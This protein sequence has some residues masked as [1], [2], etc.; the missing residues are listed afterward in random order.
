MKAGKSSKVLPGFVYGGIILGILISLWFLFRTKPVEVETA[1]VT[2]GPFI[3]DFLIDGKVRSKNKTTVVA[4][5]NGDVD[6]INLRPGDSIV[7]G[8]KITVLHW[9]YSK[10]IVSPLSGVVVKVYR[11]TAGPVNRG[12]PLI[13]IIDPED[14][15]IVA[16]PLTSDALRINENTSVKVLGLGDSSASYTAKVTTVSRAGFVKISALGVEEE[17]TEIRMA[18]VDV[19][20]KILQKLGDNFHVELSLELSRAE[21]ALKV[22]LGALFKDKENWSVYVIEN[23]KAF[24]RHI[25]L[26]K[27]NDREA[28]VSK[29]LKEGERLILFP[30][31]TI[32]EGTRVKIKN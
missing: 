20:K 30:G 27:R 19:P 8:Q 4:F 7:K 22:P 18:L 6:E 17:R 24:L 1:L 21:N 28:S 12:E 2:R 31:D 3:E 10:K 14:L 29:G 16:E 13:E 5:A 15:E 25:E 23:G 32:F 9:D 11:E 26:L